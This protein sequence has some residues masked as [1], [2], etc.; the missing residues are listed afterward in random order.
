MPRILPWKRRER[1]PSQTATSA[2]SSP[3]RRVKREDAGRTRDEEDSVLSSDAV[4]TTKKTLKRPRRTASTSP[5]P[6]PPQENFMVE[7]IDGDDRYRMVEDEFLATAQRFTAHLH[8]AEYKRLKAASELENAQMIKNI[9]RP[10]V[11]QVT[12]LVKIK[13]EKK[14]LIQKQRLAARKLRRD[15][16]GDESTGT[17][18]LND[19]W[20]KHSLYGLM[21]S[22]G[23]RA[24]RLDRLPS[25]PSVTR[26]A[27]G[28]NRQTSD[29]VSPSRPELG[30][31]YDIACRRI[32]ESEDFIDVS[33]SHGLTH[34]IPQPVPTSS[35]GA[36]TIT[37]GFKQ[38]VL[39]NSYMPTEN[40]QYSRPQVTEKSVVS[41][42]EGMDFIARL[43][44]Q[45]DERR[46]GRGQR[47]SLASKVRSDSDDIL[48]NFL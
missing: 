15:G 19:S 2:R 42:D 32:H 7:G 20:Q 46:R 3:V 45:Q 28:F 41:D 34:R 36:E 21:E 8:A 43:K 30:P 18:D 10:V 25:A 16:S 33:S 39:S 48:P 38:P 31:T 12:D 4:G 24:K 11:G 22:P 26:A 1:A 13:Q 6:E 9:S 5:P 35:R 40:P 17:D 37:S 44:K 29:V 23:K 27:A 47:K 14:A